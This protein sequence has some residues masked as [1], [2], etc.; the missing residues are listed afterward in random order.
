MVPADSAVV[1]DDVCRRGSSVS[2]ARQR[3]QLS[4]YPK[5]RVRQRSTGA[6]QDINKEMFVGIETQ[7]AYLLHL[8]PLLRVGL[9]YCLASRHRRRVNV[10]LSVGHVVF[11]YAG[12]TSGQ[13]TAK[14]EENVKAAARRA[15]ARLGSVYSCDQVTVTEYRFVRR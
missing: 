4:T 15:R 1:D 11:E 5:P 14:M 6:I 13:E 7:R 3:R 10:H 9:V 8:E 2:H 12:R